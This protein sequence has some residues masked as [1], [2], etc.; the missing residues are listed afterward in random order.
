MTW[1][2]DDPK[3]KAWLQATE[4]AFADPRPGDSF[5]E[6]LT[7]RMFVL[8]A[9]PHGGPVTVVEAIPPCTLPQDG[10]LRRFGTADEFRAAYAYGNIPGYWIA[11]NGRGRDVQGWLRVLEAKEQ[12]ALIQRAIDVLD[13]QGRAELANVVRGLV[14]RAEGRR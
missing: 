12:G 2:D 5:D 3:V 1:L 7:F 14:E 9:E 10:K 4:D 13:A 6:M 11:L 8:A